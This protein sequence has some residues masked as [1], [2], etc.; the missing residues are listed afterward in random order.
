MLMDPGDYL[1]KRGWVLLHS[2]AQ[3]LARTSLHPTKRY[4]KAQ[5]DFLY[6]YYIDRNHPELAN[7]K[8]KAVI[9]AKTDTWAEETI[10]WYSNK[11]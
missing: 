7:E 5:Q 4:T 2:P 3:G 9:Q 6:G 11:E 1:Q 8:T 10:Y